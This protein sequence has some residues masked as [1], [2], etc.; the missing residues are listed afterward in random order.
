MRPLRRHLIGATYLLV[1]ASFGCTRGSEGSTPGAAGTAGTIVRNDMRSVA[2]TTEKTAKDIGHAAG[3]LADEA[4]KDLQDATDKAGAQGQDAW[5][6]TKVKSALTSEGLDPVHLHVDTDAKV[7]TLSGSV[8]SAAKREK[9]LD[10]A[11]RVTGVLSVKDH[12]FVKSDG[13]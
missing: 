3:N 11:K 12:L 10:A 4:G 1:S 8:D 9:A 7:V 13:R 6:T 5:I 2:K